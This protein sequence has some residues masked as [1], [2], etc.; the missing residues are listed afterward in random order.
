MFQRHTET[1]AKNVR[2]VHAN[3]SPMQNRHHDCLCASTPQIQPAGFLFQAQLCVY[4][5]RIR[6]EMHNKSLILINVNTTRQCD[7]IHV[8]IRG[9]I[10]GINCREQ[11]TLIQSNATQVCF[12]SAGCPYIFAACFGLYLGH[13]QVCQHK[14]YKRKIQQGTGSPFNSHCREVWKHTGHRI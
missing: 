10:S 7:H 9:L 8:L 14:N 6:N 12:N 3:S 5:D 11:I 4:E 1:S 2:S 13:P